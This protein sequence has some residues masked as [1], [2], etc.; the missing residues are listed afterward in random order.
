MLGDYILLVSE[1]CGLNIVQYTS[2]RIL[3]WN[4]RERE[5]GEERNRSQ[6]CQQIHQHYITYAPF[7]SLSIEH[8]D[9]LAVD[10]RHGRCIYIRI[11]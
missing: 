7:V 3:L 10:V 2:S 5:R 6:P 9:Q 4:G 11:M 8:P 1:H